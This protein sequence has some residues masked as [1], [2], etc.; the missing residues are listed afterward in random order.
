MPFTE[1]II[2]NFKQDSSTRDAMQ[3]VWPSASDVFQR[4]ASILSGLAGPIVLKNGMDV[5]DGLNLMCLFG[6]LNSTPIAV[7]ILVTNCCEEWES[8][9]GFEDFLSSKEFE[10]FIGH[11]GPLLTEPATPQL[12]RTNATP[13]DLTESPITE[14]VRLPA[15]PN[16]PR[17]SVWEQLI[18]AIET[19]SGHAHP[20]IFGHSV[21]L[22]PRLWL[23]IVTWDSHEVRTNTPIHDRYN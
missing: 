7:S 8:Q 14:I 9:N 10:T 2:P 1:V 6:E 17:D 22:E 5:R 4:T 21:N 13:R 16:Y 3:K 20:S 11:V 18:A 12:F 23:G 15:D 19:H